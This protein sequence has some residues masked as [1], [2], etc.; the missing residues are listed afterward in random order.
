MNG[1]T[2]E[3]VVWAPKSAVM[4]NF[5]APNCKPCKDF[6][7]VYDALAEEL[8]NAAAKLSEPPAVTVKF[9]RMDAT[10]NDPPEEVE[11]TEYPSVKLFV[12]GD[13]VVQKAGLAYSGKYA[14]ESVRDWLKK[15]LSGRG[16]WPS[17]S[18]L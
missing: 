16:L 14:L 12:E 3:D 6:D 8:Q 5:V 9:A 7:A 11:V 1:D 4:V 17:H 2:F 18:E 10:V 15:E 13:A